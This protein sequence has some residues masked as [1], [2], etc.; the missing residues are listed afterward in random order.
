M[1]EVVPSSSSFSSQEY[2][3]SSS[4]ASSGGDSKYENENRGGSPNHRKMGRTVGL[5]IRPDLS[6]DQLSRPPDL[7]DEVGQVTY[8]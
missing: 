2:F 8:W 4:W 7:V 6:I 5:V 3:K 1:Y